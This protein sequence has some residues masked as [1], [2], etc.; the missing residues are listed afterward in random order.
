MTNIN[1]DIPLRFKSLY[2]VTFMDLDAYGHM[3]SANIVRALIDHRF[4]QMRDVLGWTFQMTQEFK[5]G[6]YTQ[7]FDIQYLRPLFVDET[8]EIESWISELSDMQCIVSFEVR[9]QKAKLAVSAAMTLG[10][11]DKS[12]GRLIPWDPNLVSLFYQ[13]SGVTE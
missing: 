6:F 12:T 7:R 13:K 11:V 1:T 5:S 9:K 2:R 8:I 10:N 4:S 3:G